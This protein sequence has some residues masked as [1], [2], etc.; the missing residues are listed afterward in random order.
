MVEWVHRHEGHLT[1]HFSSDLQRCDYQRFGPSLY[2]P[3][4]R[5]PDDI[6][7]VDP[8]PGEEVVGRLPLLSESEN[9]TY[10]GPCRVRKR[11]ETMTEEG[12]SN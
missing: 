3:G 9:K 10:E 1:S 5:N 11:E 12:I 4:E 8:V 6:T 7:L 2:G